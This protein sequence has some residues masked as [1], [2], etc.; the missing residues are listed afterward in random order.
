MLMGLEVKAVTEPGCQGAKGL[1][2]GI[3]ALVQSASSQQVP[4]CARVP[5]PVGLTCLSGSQAGGSVPCG[6][7]WWESLVCSR[8]WQGQAAPLLAGDICAEWREEASP[9]DGWRKRSRALSSSCARA[10]GQRRPVQPACWGE[11][12][13][14]KSCGQGVGPRQL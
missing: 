7:V 1:P 12:E 2:P 4:Q 14:R 6:A 9:A 5:G 10:L 8:G 3:L 13:N 11:G